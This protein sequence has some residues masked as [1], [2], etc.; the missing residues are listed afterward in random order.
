MHVQALKNFA[1]NLVFKFYL[2]QIKLQFF[3]A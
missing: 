2:Q 1:E 3:N